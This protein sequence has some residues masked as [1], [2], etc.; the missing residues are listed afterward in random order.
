M[1]EKPRSIVEQQASL[2]GMEIFVGTYMR[3]WLSP[4]EQAKHLGKN[5]EMD[6]FK[7]LKP[8]FSLSFLVS[9]PQETRFFASVN[10]RYHTTR[11]I[12]FRV[13]KSIKKSFFPKTAQTMR[14]LLWGFPRRL[15][16]VFGILP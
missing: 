15:C 7:N 10:L 6:L 14:R 12:G 3:R 4:C 5:R 9:M 2:F 11:N 16:T 1:R 13:Q 8:I